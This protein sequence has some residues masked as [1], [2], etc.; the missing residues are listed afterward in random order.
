MVTD[1]KLDA[2]FVNYNWWNSSTTFEAENPSG[3][4]KVLTIKQGADGANFSTGIHTN[5]QLTGPL[6][7]ATLNFDWYSPSEGAKFMIRL[8]S[9][10]EINY[11]FEVT[12]DN[13]S[14]WNTTSLNVAET[15]PAVAQEWKDFSMAGAGVVFSV[16]AEG[17]ADG[18]QVSFNNVYYSNIDEA[19]KAPEDENKPA[20][21]TVPTPIHEASSVLSLFSNAYTPATTFGIGGWGQS[22][23]ANV[24]EVDG[25]NVYK[26]DFFNYMG[27]E[28]ASSINVS[29]CDTMHVDV[30]PA[31]GSKLG[32]TPISPGPRESVKVSDLT[33]GEWN[34]L[35]LPLADFAGVDMKEVFQVK[36]DQGDQDTYYL[37]NVYFYNS[38]GA[39]AI[40]A[41][42]GIVAESGAEYFNLQGQRVAA[43]AQGQIYVRVANGRASKVRF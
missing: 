21:T 10:S 15:F 8:T 27:W 4:G 22:T 16:V 24:V 9:K 5:G 29:G 41:V 6:H 3:E 14:K 34:S 38:T 43:P 17:N 11:T 13:V 31:K 19:W 37:A 30:F 33:T 18:S 23:Q 20:P 1:G 28:L 7:S 35:D 39:N 32:V 26:L 25:K 12:A 40:T 42:E 2:G 36:F